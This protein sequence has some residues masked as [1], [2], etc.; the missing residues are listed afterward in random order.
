MSLGRQVGWGMLWAK[1]GLIGLSVVSV[2]DK[3]LI[4]YC[5]FLGFFLVPLFL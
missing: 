5:C 3:S 2:E 1:E 4:P